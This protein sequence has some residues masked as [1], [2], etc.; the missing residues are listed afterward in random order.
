MSLSGL[1]SYD[2]IGYAYYLL[3]SLKKS[4]A[5]RRALNKLRPLFSKG[6]EVLKA[7]L[8]RRQKCGGSASTS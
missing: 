3:S 2:R 5:R 4:S 8:L 7:P 6:Y 1:I